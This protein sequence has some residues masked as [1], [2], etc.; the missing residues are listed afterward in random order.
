M[1][2]FRLGKGPLM[3]ILALVSLGGITAAFVRSQTRGPI[4][5]IL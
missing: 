4:S 1:D 3:L 5:P 2:P